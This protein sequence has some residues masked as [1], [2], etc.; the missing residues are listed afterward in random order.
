[1]YGQ[2]HRSGR[3]NAASSYAYHD[4]AKSLPGSGA[5]TLR[6]TAVADS[7]LRVGTYSSSNR[8]QFGTARSTTTP[9]MSA[10]ITNYSSSSIAMP[11]TA[12]TMPNLGHAKSHKR[13]GSG[14]G[15]TVQDSNTLASERE[16]FPDLATPAAASPVSRVKPYLRKLS[17]PKEDQGRLDLSRSLVDNDRLAG[18]GIQGSR[19]VFVP[20]GRHTRTTSTGSQASNHSTS[21]K[22]GQPFLHPMRQAPRPYT[23]PTGR[24]DSPYDEDDD[25]F[26]DDD[27][28]PTYPLRGKRSMS[29]SS[30]PY[31]APTPL[32]QTITIADLG[33]VPKLTSASQS[34]LSIVSTQSTRPAGSRRNTGRS[35][36]ATSPSSRTSFD[37]ISIVGGR[38]SESDS[39]TR[40]ERIRAAR[41]KFEEREADKDRK[42]EKEAAKKRE[43]ELAKALKQEQRQRSRSDA[44]EKAWPQRPGT[45][46][47]LGAARTGSALGKY[48]F[49]ASEE[50]PS[51]PAP[52]RTAMF[53]DKQTAMPTMTAKAT[54]PNFF[55][56]LFSC[57]SRRRP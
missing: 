16:P 52:S 17:M 51:P 11:P 21:S 10:G 4:A 3:S 15:S 25:D 1:M 7:E 20:P 46:G 54:S 30:V 34:N 9:S 49:R 23:P 48:S 19:D 36:V 32:S 56:R 42:A 27:H 22:P 8:S 43:A 53:S 31:G 57:G 29:N 41:R 44:S 40:D 45:S 38:R 12:R 33:A 26:V 55:T 6:K 24:S 2:S 18:L 37:K 35:E 13:S 39:R 50:R 47:G 5:R 28:R 14:S